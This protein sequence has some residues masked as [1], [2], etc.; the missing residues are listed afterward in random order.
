MVLRKSSLL[1][2]LFAA[3]VFTAVAAAQDNNALINTLIKK[4]ILSK[5]EAAQITKDLATSNNAADVTSLYGESSVSTYTTAVTG[6]VV[7][8]GACMTCIG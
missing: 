2:L 7:T 5:D 8:A 6:G 1:T 3:L 4:G